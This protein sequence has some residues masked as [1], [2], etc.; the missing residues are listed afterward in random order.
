MAPLEEEVVELA[1]VLPFNSLV[2]SH[3]VP[4]QIKATI[5]EDLYH[6][7]VESMAG[8]LLT[9]VISKDKTDRMVL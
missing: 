3:S 5:G 4:S 9:L 8:S 2:A 6:W 1:A 7:R